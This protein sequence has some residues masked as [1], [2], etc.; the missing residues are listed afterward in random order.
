VQLL[1]HDELLP[2]HLEHSSLEHLVIAALDMTGAITR[3]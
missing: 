2:D 3:S 1:A